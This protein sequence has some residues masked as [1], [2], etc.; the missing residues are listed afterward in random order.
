[1]KEGWRRPQPVE[2]F[3]LSKSLTAEMKVSPDLG[4]VHFR[5]QPK[6]LSLF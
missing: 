3:L 2:E 6:G 5:Q 4:N 1:M